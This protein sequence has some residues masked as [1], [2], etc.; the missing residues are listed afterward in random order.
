MKEH[1]CMVHKIMLSVLHTT[2][3]QMDG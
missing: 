2:L 3:L 1:I